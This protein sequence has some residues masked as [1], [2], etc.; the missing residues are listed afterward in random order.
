MC[1]STRKAY[2]MSLTMTTTD[3][4]NT[5][6]DLCRSYRWLNH[7]D[8]WTSEEDKNLLFIAQAKGID[9]ALNL[10]T[11]TEE[12]DSRLQVAIEEH[13]YCHMT[14][15]ENN[16]CTQPAQDVSFQK[17]RENHLQE[18]II[19]LN[20]HML[21]FKRRGDNCLE[22]IRITVIKCRMM[23]FRLQTEKRKQPESSKCIESVQDNSS[24]HP[25]STLCMTN[26]Q[27]QSFG[28]S[29]TVKRRKN[30]V[31][32][33][34]DGAE[35]AQSSSVELENLG[36]YE[37]LYQTKIQE[38]NMLEVEGSLKLR[39]SRTIQQRKIR[40][41]RELGSIARAERATS[42]ME[43]KLIACFLRNR[44]KKRRQES[45]QLWKE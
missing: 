9:P 10:G 18:L 14:P 21:R 25:L 1:P 11:W 24:S 3:V 22:D 32:G 29:L 19:I 7:E 39:A 15:L 26:N 27:A 33:G 4:L 44:S 13:G 43:M 2:Q 36:V 16:K 12:E 8:P 6:Q 41:R 20:Q 40:K 35:V 42:N 28:S 17:K 34:D 45:Y 23:L 38:E 5:V 37:E 31:N 30:Y